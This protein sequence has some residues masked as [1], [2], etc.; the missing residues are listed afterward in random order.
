MIDDRAIKVRN[1]S[2]T[3]RDIVKHFYDRSQAGE[4]DAATAQTMAKEALRKV[5]Y[6]GVEYFFIYDDQGNCVLLPPKP[7]REGKN[8]LDLKDANGVHF[9]RPVAKVA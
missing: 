9:I 3:G 8:F 5:R 2:E 7:E 1:I 6:D 4:F